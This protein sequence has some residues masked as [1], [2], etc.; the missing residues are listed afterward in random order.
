MVIVA[1]TPDDAGSG[2]VGLFHTNFDGVTIRGEYLSIEYAL[3]Q[4]LSNV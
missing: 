4:R 2:G 1:Y 3:D